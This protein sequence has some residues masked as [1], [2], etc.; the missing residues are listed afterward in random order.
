MEPLELTQKGEEE[1]KEQEWGAEEE[2]KSEDAP[3][4]LPKIGVVSVC[5][6]STGSTIYAGCT[7]NVIRIYDVKENAA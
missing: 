6:D 5:I 4:N 7:D 1:P 2:A 3:K